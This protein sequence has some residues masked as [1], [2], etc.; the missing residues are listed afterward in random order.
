MAAGTFDVHEGLTSGT[1]LLRAHVQSAD[2]AT[3]YPWRNDGTNTAVKELGTCS[4]NAQNT[5][6][7]AKTAAEDW[8]SSRTP[9]GDE[10]EQP[11]RVSTT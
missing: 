7:T 6:N 5:R 10:S 3:K 2:N 8:T 4:N 9:G 11:S 1:L